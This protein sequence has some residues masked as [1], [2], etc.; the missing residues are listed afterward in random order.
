MLKSLGAAGM[1]GLA[2]CGGSGDGG[3]G[4]GGGDG[5][6]G[7]GGNGGSTDTASDDGEGSDEP[8]DIGYVSFSLNLS[9]FQAY[10]LAGEWWGQ[11]NG[12]NVN[13]TNGELD[14]TKQARDIQNFIN[15]GVDAIMVTPADSEA[16]VDPIEDALAENI[17]VFT[18]DATAATDEIGMYTGFDNQFAG[19]RVGENTV[20]TLEEENGEPSGQVLE[21][22]LQ[23]TS[24]IGVDR[25]ESFLEV[26]D[27]YP[28]IEVN[29]LN[30]GNSQE[31]SATKTYNA[32]QRGVP[33]LVATH[34]LNPM[35][36]A[37]NAL[38]RSNNWYPIGE[39][40]HVPISTIDGGPDLNQHVADGF[41]DAIF[42]QPIQFF[43]P[44]A[45]KFMK[46]YLD[47]GQDEEALPTIGDSYEA[48]DL[49]I[50]GQVPQDEVGIDIWA[51]PL[52]APGEVREHPVFD[53]QR[54]WRLPAVQL[55]PENADN[56]YYWGNWIRDAPSY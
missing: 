8:Y 40:G 41:I 20:S 43:Q 18:T 37:V 9:L 24:Q 29:S 4:G 7:S 14:A 33:D 5:S 11:E 28:D 31:E 15:S 48:G 30:V 21:L 26:V 34:G 2:G 12:M 17:P 19:Q 50:S 25:H 27:E 46:D 47:A 56:P 51:E 23:Q 55:T 49:D 39:D 6:D 32:L 38:E 16:I 35:L 22:T 1:I 52:W 10:T 54:W 44:I 36:G 3:D 13:V 53:G 42:D 45:L